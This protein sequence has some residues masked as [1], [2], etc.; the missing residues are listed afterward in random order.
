MFKRNTKKTVR[1]EVFTNIH[2]YIDAQG[3]YCVA[4][5]K[6]DLS[7]QALAHPVETNMNPGHA[8]CFKFDTITDANKCLQ[9]IYLY[10]HPKA[11]VTNATKLYKSQNA[12]TQISNIEYRYFFRPEFNHVWNP[13]NGYTEWLVNIPD[14]KTEYKEMMGLDLHCYYEQYAKQ[15]EKEQKVIAKEEAK[16]KK[17][18]D[19][20]VKQMIKER[21]RKDKILC[22][23]LY[24]GAKK[25][26]YVK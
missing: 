11:R 22:H 10:L 2:L 13:A 3:K 25:L 7:V 14:L 19:K 1:M 15:I 20:R 23:M 9:A 18:S 8:N 6:Q 5:K 12:K 24:R 17:L 26:G 16:A 21:D 4:Y